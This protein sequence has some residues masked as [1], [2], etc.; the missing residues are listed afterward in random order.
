MA[1]SADS[2]VVRARA[3]FVRVAPRKARLVADQ[4]RGLP[5]SEAKTLLE[6]SSRGAARD[7]AK[8][9]DSA[10]AN[11]EA[12]HDLIADELRVADI[13]VDEGPTLKR[14]R[15]RARGR[16]TRIDKRTSH[17]SVALTPS[18]E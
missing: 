17:L 14:W 2:P 4:V 15:P 11:A 3:R 10:A 16:A 1:E 18:E 8:L 12:N 9:I 13:R 6:F 5:V 7:L